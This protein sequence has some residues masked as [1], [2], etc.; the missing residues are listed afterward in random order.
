MTDSWFLCQKGT[1]KIEIIHFNSPSTETIVDWNEKAFTKM[2]NLKTL[3]IENV[4]FD[5][6]ERHLPTS[7]RVLKWNRCPLES[8]SSSFWNKAS[9]VNSLFN[10]LYL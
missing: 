4:H 1:R 10:C 7:L 9:E 3:I 5:K 8:L 6:G 2:R